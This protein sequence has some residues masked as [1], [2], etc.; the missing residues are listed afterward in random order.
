MSNKRKQ[1][2]LV[3]ALAGSFGIFL[4]K[5]LG[6][7]YVVP[8]NQLAGETNMAF[9]SIT[10]SY[11]DL[12]LKICGAGIPFA[13]AAL[14]AKYY[15]RGDYKTVLLVRKL[16]TSFIM[17][18]SFIIALLFLLVAH[19]LATSTMGSQASIEDI[20]TLYNLF[21]IL[22]VAIIF[23][24]LLS[25]IRGY[26]QGLKRMDIYASS[27]VLEQFFRVGGIV[28][29]GY[30]FVGFMHFDGKWAI[31]MAMFS[32]GLA[33]IITIIYMLIMTRNENQ[34]VAM[35]AKGQGSGPRNAKEVFI[36]LISLGIPYVIISFL[37]TSSSIVN[38]NFFMSYA[39]SVGVN[40][41]D[42]LLVLGILQVNC[43]KIA[44]IPQVLTLGFS[45]GLVPYLTE[46]LEKQ[47]FINLKKQLT[48]IFDTVFYFLIPVV[49]GFILFAKAIYFIMY[50]NANLELGAEVFAFSNI[51]TIT[52]TVA[53][54]L[55]SILITLRQ[56]KN[57]IIILALS[58]VLKFV[59]FFPLVAISGYKGMIFSSVLCSLLVIIMSFILLRRNYA[60]SLKTS[61]KRLLM[62]ALASA[63]ALLPSA[64]I[65]SLWPLNY[66][67]RFICLFFLAL[68]AIVSAGLYLLISYIFYLPQ[69]I[70]HLKGK[71]ILKLFSRFKG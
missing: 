27:Q 39:P 34:E 53:P 26:Y 60:F 16:G 49:F 62:I 65:N 46:S 31:Y 57:A 12:L 22:L 30:F 45:A 50:G 68:H 17:A 48:E 54:I 56:R 70:F 43:N 55:S 35:L 52:D 66:E 47:D 15:S 58:F 28:A 69:S 32:A 20:E 33:A 13:I 40:Y 44:A 7:F 25:S 1:S 38:S 14:V 36:E 10:Y 11:Y 9:Y 19:P 41:D 67:S 24:P 2:L 63:L 8:L 61:A 64:L 59:S 4:S 23:V 18:S 42:A 51:Q 37:G 71:D 5:A 3:G 29:L 6:L 21:R